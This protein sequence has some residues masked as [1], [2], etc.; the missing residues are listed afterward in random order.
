MKLAAYTCNF[1]NYR[2]DISAFNALTKDDLDP[3]IDY[4]FFTDNKNMTSSEWKIIYTPLIPSD[5]EIITSDRLTS[6]HIKFIPPAILD[7]YDILIWI[8][9]KQLSN[10]ITYKNIIKLLEKY[11]DYDIFN[12]Q[13]PER[14]SIQEEIEFT[15]KTEVENKEHGEKFL[16][17]VSDFKSPFTLPETCIIILKNTTSNKDVFNHCY[18]LI[19]TYKL[20]RDQNIYNYAF[21]E[22]NKIPLILPTIPIL[23]NNSQLLPKTLL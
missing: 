1:G 11:P 5:K 16:K 18:T 4:Y 19:N 23:L 20:K 21:Y 17:K 7:T 3:Q 2:N 22:K 13:H 15:I 9:C 8:D 14:K 12:L 10:K 6:K